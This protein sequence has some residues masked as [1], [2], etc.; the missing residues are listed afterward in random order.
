MIPSSAQ[1]T[2]MEWCECVNVVINTQSLINIFSL[3]KS[4]RSD[5]WG[6]R[7]AQPIRSTYPDNAPLPGPVRNFMMST[8][9]E[10]LAPASN[11]RS[12]I[13]QSDQPQTLRTQVFIEKH[14]FIILFFGLYNVFEV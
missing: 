11:A 4:S 12:L 5:L 13:W 9:F 3:V 1:N 8:T 14:Q 7:Y 2:R 6:R 10:M